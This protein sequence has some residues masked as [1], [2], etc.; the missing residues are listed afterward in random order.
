[1]GRNLLRT[2]NPSHQDE[3]HGYGFDQFHWGLFSRGPL[4]TITASNRTTPPSKRRGA[5]R[6]VWQSRIVRSLAVGGNGVGLVAVVQFEADVIPDDAGG[7]VS[8]GDGDGHL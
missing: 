2:R 3:R 1:M 5:S 4:Y 6:L 7:D 8:C